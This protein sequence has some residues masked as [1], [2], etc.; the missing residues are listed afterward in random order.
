MKTKKSSPFD[1][2]FHLHPAVVEAKKFALSDWLEKAE[3]LWVGSARNFRL[4]ANTNCTLY[5]FPSENLC[6]LHTPDGW[7]RAYLGQEEAAYHDVEFMWNVHVPSLSAGQEIPLYVEL[8][9][10]KTEEPMSFVGRIKSIA[11]RFKPKKREGIYYLGQDHDV[12][13]LAPVVL[14]TIGGLKPSVAHAIVMQMTPVQREAN[15]RCFGTGISA[16]TDPSRLQE[17]YG[18][19]S[20]SD[21]NALIEGRNVWFPKQ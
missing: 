18:T 1:T 6:M 10:K 13:T 3:V 8:V 12:D 4:W 20:G 2:A 17:I 16:G 11:G 21:A 14:G 9:V 19:D 15:M 7:V 5:A